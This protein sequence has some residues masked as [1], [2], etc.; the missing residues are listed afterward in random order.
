MTDLVERYVHQVGRYLP[1]S[2]RADVV[3]ELR[4]V[5][6]DQLEDRF[7][8][9]PTD[10]EVSVVLAE[11]GDPRQMAASYG[12]QQVLIGPELYPY[13]M[14]VLRHGWLIIPS[15]VIFL[16]VFGL[17]ISGQ[18]VTPTNLL[19]DP[20]WA[21]VQVTFV[22]SALVVLLFAIIERVA[23]R[24]DVQE[25]PFNP[26]ALPQVNDPLAVVRTDIAWGVALGIIF[27]LIMIYYLQ[28]GG[29]TLNFNLS[30]PGEVIPI[31][32]N[33]MA[34]LIVVAIAQLG[35]HSLML[36]RKRW[37]IS[38][39]IFQVFLEV[40]GAIC[41]YFAVL[42]PFFEHVVPADSAIANVPLALI[43]ALTSAIPTLFSRGAALAQRSPATN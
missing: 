42:E 28:V 3:A 27:T 23:A 9:E 11:L 21:M 10:A 17:L 37:P 14:M 40:F 33:W 35:I 13:M 29:L 12:E 6:Y 4:S 2:E 31:P 38:L 15:V 32:T 25:P 39:W 36:A 5:I 1:R 19:L 34:L 18:P 22:F 41:L 26:A 20:L 30:D 16:G 43:I 24:Y 7:G 8:P